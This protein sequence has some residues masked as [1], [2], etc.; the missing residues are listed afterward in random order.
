[1]FT[2]EEAA[3]VRSQRLARVATVSLNGQPDV[4][5]VGFQWDG[6]VFTFGGLRLLTTRKA[7]NIAA[8]AI[9]VALIVD[10]GDRESTGRRPRG[11][12]IHGIAEIR[13]DGE[14]PLIAIRP[15]TSWSWGILDVP[16]SNGKPIFHRIDWTSES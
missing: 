3:Y 15:V 9:R 11:I 6:T 10:D 14:R 1:V 4:D 16:Y 7:K 2:D 8:G 13:D 5:A 12:K